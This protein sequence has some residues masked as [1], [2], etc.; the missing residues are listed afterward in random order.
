MNKIIFILFLLTFILLINK[1]STNEDFTNIESN[2]SYFLPKIIYCYW[3]DEKNKLMNCFLNNWKKKLS[4][5]W[6]VSFINNNNILNFVSQE[7]LNKYSYLP[8]FRFSDFLIHP[9]TDYK[10]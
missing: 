3:D 8:S 4:K 9:R 10:F 5:G 7:F 6:T 2:S 1:L